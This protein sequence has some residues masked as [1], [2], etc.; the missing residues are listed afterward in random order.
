MSVVNWDIVSQFSY[1]SI[2]CLSGFAL[3]LSF[4][5]CS[6][7]TSLLRCLTLLFPILILLDML[8]VIFIISVLKLIESEIQHYISWLC[9]KIT[10]F[11]VFYFL[12]SAINSPSFFLR[13]CFSFFSPLLLNCS[14]PF[15]SRLLVFLKRFISIILFPQAKMIIALQRNSHIFNNVQLFRQFMNGRWMAFK[16]TYQIL[17]LVATRTNM[18][19]TVDRKLQHNIC[20]V[21]HEN[22]SFN[23]ASWSAL[24]SS[25][26]NSLDWTSKVI[27]YY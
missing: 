14:P 3:P 16:T 26:G 22:K 13:F 11:A 8:A 4:R 17:N 10:Y 2:P 15:F 20:T 24:P 25:S 21:G 1:I 27:Y 9:V 7:F 5:A 6:S 18:A 23:L 12:L 19:A